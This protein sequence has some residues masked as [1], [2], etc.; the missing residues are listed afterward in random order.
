MNVKKEF[1]SFSKLKGKGYEHEEFNVKH[2]INEMKLRNARTNFRIRS[3]MIPCKMNMKSNT[4]F[5]SDLWKCD[6]CLSIYSQS[7]ILWC[8]AYASLRDG[9]SLDNDND[10][11]HYY[12]EVMNE[13]PWRTVKQII[14]ILVPRDCRARGI[15]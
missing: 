8:P 14:S 15:L 12:Q 10:I 5:A 6:E 2:Y 3:S 9:K 11:V 4:K 1:R 7:H 13:N